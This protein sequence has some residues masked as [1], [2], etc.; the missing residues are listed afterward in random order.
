MFA[1]KVKLYSN[2]LRFGF[3]S[4]E[5]GGQVFFHNSGVTFRNVCKDDDVEFDID[6]GIRGPRAVNIRK[7]KY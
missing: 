2:P 4:K 1:G 7:V 5:G 3:I 6:E